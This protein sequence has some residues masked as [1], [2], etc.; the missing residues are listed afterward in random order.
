[1]SDLYLVDDHVVLRDGLKAVLEA[2]GHRV[3]GG[4]GDPTRALAD[5]LRLTPH[6]LLLDLNLGKRSGFEL[7]EEIRRRNLPVHCVVLTMSA[8]PRHVLDAMRLGVLSYLLKGSSAGEVIKAV[9]AAARGERYTTAETADLAVK[10]LSMRESQPRL[11][12]LS[13][14]ERQVITLVV[15]GHSSTEIGELLHLSPKTVDSYR[16][17]LMSKL[18]VSDVTALVRLAI[19][20]GLIEPLTP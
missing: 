11:D 20:L 13:A 14:R 18:G 19:H 15:Q 9:D 8:Q 17:R 1:M 12:T 2:Q 7:L 10:A 6:V 16:S 5:L 4:C 3:V